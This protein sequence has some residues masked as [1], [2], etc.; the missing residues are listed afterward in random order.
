MICHAEGL[1]GSELDALQSSIEALNARARRHK[2]SSLCSS[3]G[4]RKTQGRRNHVSDVQFAQLQSS[5]AKLSFVN[6]ENSKKVHTIDH[7]LK[8][9]ET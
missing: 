5:M 9:Q 6:I 4:K 3:A 1:K 7:V 2:Q 8:N